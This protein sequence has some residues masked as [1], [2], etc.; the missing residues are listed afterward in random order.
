MVKVKG[1]TLVWFVKAHP[2]DFSGAACALGL[3]LRT[4]H[5]KAAV[6]ISEALLN[7]S[8]ALPV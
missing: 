4:K 8:S 7:S 5:G 6:P 2:S 1:R 3:F